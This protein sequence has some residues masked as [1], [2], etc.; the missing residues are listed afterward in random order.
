VE[1][2]SASAGTKDDFSVET[3][4]TSDSGATS[5]YAQGGEPKTGKF[6][7]MLLSANV[8]YVDLDDENSTNQVMKYQYVMLVGST[9]FAGLGS[10]DS[11][12]FGNGS[13]M[14]SA[15]RTMGVERYSLDIEYKPINDVAL[16]IETNVATRL[17][18]IICAVL[19]TLI[20]I[21]GLVVFV[22]RRHL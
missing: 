21:A 7:L 8:D 22:R 15:A 2:Y 6:P 9:D 1:L 17:G 11:A 10:I 18:I 19:P 20:L 12:A 13:L 3:V 5:T 14:L 4:L 16:A